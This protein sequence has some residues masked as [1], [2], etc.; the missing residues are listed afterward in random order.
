MIERKV[1]EY[2]DHITV[3]YDDSQEMKDKVFQYLIDHY[4]FK[5]K[6]FDGETICQCDKPII[7]APFAMEE[8]ADKIIKFEVDYGD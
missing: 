6:A 3:T 4:F 1:V 5:Y 2:G 8:I 7:G